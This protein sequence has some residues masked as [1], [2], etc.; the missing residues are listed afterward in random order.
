MKLRN[1]RFD[2]LSEAMLLVLG[3]LTGVLVAY[4][5]GYLA[6]LFFVLGGVLRVGYLFWRAARADAKEHPDIYDPYGNDR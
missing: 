1:E 4:S 6:G 2:A 5:L 3:Q